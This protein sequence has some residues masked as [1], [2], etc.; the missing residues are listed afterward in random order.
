[1]PSRPRHFALR[2]A[3]LAPLAALVTI[4]LAPSTACT[5]PTVE[6]ADA[7]A[8]AEASAEAD[9]STE[10]DASAEAGPPAPPCNVS[11]R[12]ADLTRQCFEGL[13]KDYESCT[14]Q[15]SKPDM[16]ACV[17]MCKAT[18]AA[19]LAQCIMSCESCGQTDGCANGTANCHMILGY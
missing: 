9:A 11:N 6:Y 4:A 12:C 2:C 18:A 14:R 10:A 7:D 1:M 8:S 15:C 16:N 19:Q 17:D 3:A 13:K 5:F